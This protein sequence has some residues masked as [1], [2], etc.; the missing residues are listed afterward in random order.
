MNDLILPESA[1]ST[2]MKRTNYEALKQSAVGIDGFC[3]ALHMS[4]F[5]EIMIMA[6]SIEKLQHLC[7]ALTGVDL[8]VTSIGEVS[9][10]N[11][12]ALKEQGAIQI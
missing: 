4:P 1:T 12:Q 10:L 11:R 6:D 3:A 8:D 2:G 9:I 7:K 5:G